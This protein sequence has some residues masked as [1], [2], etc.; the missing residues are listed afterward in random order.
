MA[1]YAKI[2][3]FSYAGEDKYYQRESQLVFVE[4]QMVKTGLCI[5]YDLCFPEMFQAL[6]RTNKLILNTAN[7]PE[8]CVL[9]WRTMIQAKVIENQVFFIGVS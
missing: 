8:W 7:W 6:S 5:C 3:P 1:D 9:H 2:H 4:I